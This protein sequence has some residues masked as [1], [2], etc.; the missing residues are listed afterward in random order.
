M[1]DKKQFTSFDS[2]N[3]DNLLKSQA[4]LEDND[5]NISEEGVGS[6]IFT[7][8]WFVDTSTAS[9]TKN[10]EEYL[11]ENNISNNCQKYVL[12][13]LDVFIEAIGTNACLIAKNRDSDTLNFDDVIL[14]AEK[15]YDCKFPIGEN[16]SKIASTDPEHE[17]KIEQVLRENMKKNNP[18]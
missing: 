10:L 8:S 7:T 11:S 3:D 14:A 13:M 4:K 18:K 5:E 9:K 16:F 15:T 6:K 17:K 1:D 2:F 12:D